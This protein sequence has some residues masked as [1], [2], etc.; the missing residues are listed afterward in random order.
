MKRAVLMILDGL[1]ADF[2]GKETT[3]CLT[4]IA[5]SSRVYL[6]H[7][8]V[9]PSATRVNAAS[10]A[11]GCYPSGHG[12]AG[13]TIAL[14]EGDG[15]KPV[16]VGPKDFRDRLRRATGRTLHRPTLSERLADR[17]GAR[18]F[19]N[20][21]PGA[22]HMHDPDGY[23]YVYH[24]SG[25]FGPGLEPITGGAHLDISHDSIGDAHATERLCESILQGDDTAL[26]TLWICEPDHSQHAMAL[27]SDEH[28]EVVRA[29]DACARWVH[30]AV[31]ALRS[32]GDDVVL[33]LGS[34]HGHETV[35]EVIPVVDL[36]VAAGLKTSH[37]STEMV[38]AS[39]GMGALV[40][41]A[42]NDATHRAEVA[43]W[44][45]N[46][47]WIGPVYAGERLGEVNLPSDTRLGI[48]FSMAKR[49]VANKY[50]VRG[51]GS[52][53]A[54]AIVSGDR[55][56]IGQHGGLGAYETR[57][58]LVVN[59]RA[60]PPGGTIEATVNVDIAPTILAH[61]GVQTGGMD[62]RDLPV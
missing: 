35:D 44:L 8:S 6:R 23:G 29:A 13:N 4:E 52:V 57:P 24:R 60:F 22:A 61:L 10:I 46:Q 31:E 19:A 56:G 53:A 40:Y 33:I 5:Q 45:S 15:L 11:T 12:L 30:E 41:L 42:D 51:L 54:D 59:G 38:I 58:F 21:S 34:D 9:F 37:E 49:D 32:R 62:G 3:P 26:F 1:R 20:A 25:S 43:G 14:D 18:V 39:S 55:P 28:L 47:P 36:M 16:S 48:A 2:V 17:G 50:G 27:G 7:R